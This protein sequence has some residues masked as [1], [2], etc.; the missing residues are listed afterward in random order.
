MASAEPSAQIWREAM[1][2]FDRLLALG[3]EDRERELAGLSSSRPDLHPHVVTLL[4]ADASAEA[5]GFLSGPP[6]ERV[7]ANTGGLGDSLGVSLKAGARFGTYE[8]VRELGC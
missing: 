7:T 8:L 2:C 5:H 6:G 1:E 3:A 4:R